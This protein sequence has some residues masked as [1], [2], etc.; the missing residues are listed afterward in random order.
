LLRDFAAES[1]RSSSDFDA[2]HMNVFDEL[3]RC[4]PTQSGLRLTFRCGEA[5]RT[6]ELGWEATGRI[7]RALEVPS[8]KGMPA[9]RLTLTVL[10]HQVCRAHEAKGLLLRTEEWGSVVFSLPQEIL[11]KLIA[12]LVHLASFPSGTRREGK[13]RLCR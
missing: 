6:I 2:G 5:D 12:D 8:E 1:N 10:G 3:L 11:P 13:H 9:E 4:V 7:L